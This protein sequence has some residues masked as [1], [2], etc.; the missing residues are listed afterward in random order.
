MK[1]LL[2]SLLGTCILVF[3]LSACGGSKGGPLTWLDRPLDNTIIPLTRLTIQAH[4]SDEDGISQIEFFI[5]DT[6]LSTVDS[7]GKRL[8]EALVEWTPPEPGVYTI[9]ARGIDKGGNT[10]SLATAV[11]IVEA[12]LQAVISSSIQITNV[13]CGDGLID[14]VD[15]NIN[16]PDGILSYLVFSTWVAAETGE[17]F[18][19]PY[20]KTMQ[21][22]VQLTEPFPDDID[23]DHQIGL[24]VMIVN[25]PNP[26]FAY[27]FEPN[28]RCPGHYSE[29]AGITT[30]T[31]TNSPMPTKTP[32]RTS[33]PPAT[34]P[35]PPTATQPPTPADTTPPSFFS[36]GISEDTILIEGPGCPSY[37][38]TTT[39]AAA[40]GDEGGLSSVVA[41]W[42]I[43]GGESGQVTLQEGQLGY[44]AS[45]GP[46][47]TTGTMEIYVV[48]IDNSGNAAQSS[49]VYVTV[50][51]CI[52]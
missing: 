52:T 45:I 23:R 48:A 43:S 40:V 27:A 7:D 19:A 42:S 31:P 41:Y 15:I 28:N 25:D 51:Q 49:T 3:V 13:T 22:Q 30:D 10:G 1:R 24:K 33:P 34:Q 2:I 32:T 17:T 9:K 20:P 44:Y 14:Y 16:H 5:D 46:V 39:I 8:G 18:T 6:L 38:R 36:V 29:E 12:E 47:T 37:E 50:N 4:S 35:P 26:V 21:K 11:V